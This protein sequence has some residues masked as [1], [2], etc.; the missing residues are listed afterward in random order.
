MKAYLDDQV[1]IHLTFLLKKK[2]EKKKKEREREKYREKM[3]LVAQEVSDGMCMLF[4]T[5]YV[6]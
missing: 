5:L 2:K 3:A 1:Q 6:D 4:P